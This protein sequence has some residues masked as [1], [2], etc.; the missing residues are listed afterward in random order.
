[1]LQCLG[2]ALSDSNSSINFF[3]FS[4][5]S[6]FWGI[7]FSLKA[8]PNGMCFGG[9]NLRL[10]GSLRADQSL[11]LY[12]FGLGRLTATD[13]AGAKPI[14]RYFEDSTIG[15]SLRQRYI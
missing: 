2:R 1:M 5:F 7:C 9:H 12:G 10:L 14:A 3:H 6:A 15:F 13:S 8:N 4:V 11:S